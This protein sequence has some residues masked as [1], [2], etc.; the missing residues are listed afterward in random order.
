MYLIHR[1]ISIVRILGYKNARYIHKLEVVMQELK[2]S[3]AR[4]MATGSTYGA[5]KEE[6]IERT[7]NVRGKMS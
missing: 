6:V 3:K 7:R 1:V 4:T 2:V 5:R